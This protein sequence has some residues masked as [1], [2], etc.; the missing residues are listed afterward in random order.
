MKNSTSRLFLGV[1]GVAGLLMMCGP[2]AHAQSAAVQKTTTVQK[3]E[4][5]PTTGEPME[6]ASADR[7]V[8]QADGSASTV[9]ITDWSSHHMVFSNPAKAKP[10]V[11]EKIVTNP[12]Y[13]M[14]LKRQALA[15]RTIKFNSE[16]DRIAAESAA[17]VNS[18][19]AS[20]ALQAGLT[21]SK[22]QPPPPPPPAV[23][24][25]DWNMSL[26]TGTVAPGQFPAEV[27][28]GEST[29]TGTGGASP[30]G[31]CLT[32]FVIFGL[33]TVGTNT[34]ANLIAF[35]DLYSGTTGSPICGTTANTKWAY[36]TSTMSPPGSVSNSPVTSGD[37]T[38]VAFVENNNSAASLHI[39]MWKDS[40]GTINAPVTPTAVASMSACSAAPCMATVQ[41]TT[42]GDS[43]SSPFYDFITD[44]AYVGDNEGFL[45]AITGVFYGTPTVSNTAPFS[46]GGLQVSQNFGA[47]T[48]PVYDF[49]GSG[50]IFVGS[51]DGYL[52][53]VNATTG[54][55]TPL[56]VG[57]GFGSGAI[58]DPPTVDSSNQRVI[59]SA[60]ANA[61]STSAVAVQADTTTPLGNPVTAN[62]GS[63]QGS[64]LAAEQ[65]AFDNNYYNWSGTGGN[66]GHF[67]VIGS[68]ATTT[69]PTLYEIPFGGV[70]SVNISGTTTT[71]YTNPT[72]TFS[73][74]PQGAKFTATG[75][76]SG[77]IFGITGGLAGTGFTSFPGVTVTGTG[78]GATAAVTDVKVLTAALSSG[79]SNYGA[80]PTVAFTGGTGETG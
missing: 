48:A 21:S 59:V 22:K 51:A 25:R 20:S 28:A 39:L 2:G 58:T 15:S 36:N 9:V 44:T 69:A 61:A 34:Q 6:K 23:G 31:N 75:S 3:A 63:I 16:A 18:V 19:K 54:N 11:R 13:I 43:I 29:I 73:A 62:I 66:P 72:V 40:N 12:R 77:G 71:G 24:T 70:N 50:N 53:A 45:Y 57:S 52:Y 78:T 67:F 30:T 79:G 65:G 10:A 33:N 41:F 37:G 32:D 38:M 26:G 4:P 49:T 27:T 56:Q 17:S 60:G 8:V 5:A 74:S 42:N 68:T 35:D 14:Q 55:V 7:Q 64:S 1:M 46:T 76:G 80:V 47:L